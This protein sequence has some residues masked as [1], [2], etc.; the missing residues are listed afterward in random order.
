VREAAEKLC[1]IEHNFISRLGG[2]VTLSGVDRR[3]KIL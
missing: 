1:M 2:Q 3:Q